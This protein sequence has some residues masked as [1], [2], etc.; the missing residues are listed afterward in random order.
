VRRCDGATQHAGEQA[1]EPCL[2]IDGQGCAC[3]PTTHLLVV[4]PDLPELGVWRLTTRGWAAA[5]EIPQ[6]VELVLRLSG[7]GRLPEA[8]LQIERRTRRSGGT[9]QHFVVPVLRIPRSV[10]ELASRA[11]V[12]LPEDALQLPG[13]G[14]DDGDPPGPGP[15]A[16]AGESHPQRRSHQPAAAR[17]TSEVVEGEAA[18]SDR[19]EPEAEGFGEGPE[20]SGSRCL[21]LQ[22][23]RTVIDSR[24]RRVEVCADCGLVLEVA[25]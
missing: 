6:A 5:S 22:G 24:G 7:S 11:P 10:T 17:T 12:P 9:T 13:P 8:V 23:T 19:V 3:Q 16:A 18:A 21:H 1:G 4:L 15:R 14:D 20:A 25:K 2:R